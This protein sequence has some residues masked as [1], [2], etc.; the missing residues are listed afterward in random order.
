MKYEGFEYNKILDPISKTIS[1]NKICKAFAKMLRHDL[2]LKD[3]I[4]KTPKNLIISLMRHVKWD[5]LSE[6]GFFISSFNM[7]SLR[8]FYSLF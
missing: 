8:A 1:Q 7:P 5:F 2:Q 6:Q 3:E 4:K